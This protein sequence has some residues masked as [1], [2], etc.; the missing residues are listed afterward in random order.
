LSISLNKYL[1]TQEDD[2]MDDMDQQ[3]ESEKR[4]NAQRDIIRQ[5]LDA[6]TNDIGIA[7]RDSGLT[8]PV[9]ITVRNSGD[10]LVTIATSLDPSDEEWEHARQIVCRTLEERV[11]CDRLGG[12]ELACAVANAGAINAADVTAA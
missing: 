11:G 6:I 2:T 12:R 1:H 5:S 4:L 3:T 7:M 8:F 9:Y 10:A